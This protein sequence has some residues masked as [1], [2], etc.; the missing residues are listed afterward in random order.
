LFVGAGASK[1][2]N[3]PSLEE[4]IRPVVELA[5]GAFNSSERKSGS[6]S[7]RLADYFRLVHGVGKEELEGCLRNPSE[8]SP[9]IVE[10]LTLLDLAISENASFGHLPSKGQFEPREF[11]GNRLRRVHR[12]IVGAIAS[13]LGVNM[14]PKVGSSDADGLDAYRKLIA[15]SAPDSAILTTNWDS[16]I[17][18][19]IWDVDPESLHTWQPRLRRVVYSPIAETIVRYDGTPI[20]WENES[21]LP[22]TMLIKLHGSVNWLYCPRCNRL[23]ISPVLDLAP[24]SP[25]RGH[26]LG[27][28]HWI[29]R[30]CW[31][32]AEA[33]ALIV[34]P[35]FSKSYNNVQLRA[36]WREGLHALAHASEWTFVGYSLPVDDFAVRALITRALVWKR[37]EGLPLNAVRVYG[38]ANEKVRDTAEALARSP[39]SARG[40]KIPEAIRNFVE[41]AARYR[42]IL[43]EHALKLNVFGG[44]L[45]AA[46][47]D[48]SEG[49]S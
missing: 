46:A 28:S 35:S 25:S 26:G 22:K 14:T 19:L 39:N 45:A 13:G 20:V 31:C 48:L 10:V 49:W 12:S 17:D 47:K 1:P 33:E 6:S 3:G 7:R 41:L 15:S 34:T 2:L 44:G 5:L 40:D 23:I 37:S 42:A 9:G 36:I 38:W 24:E 8:W 30:T 16:V 11:S 27:D 32:E 43:A 4:T 21:T 29:D 18:R